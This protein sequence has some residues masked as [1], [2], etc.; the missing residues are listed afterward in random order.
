MVYLD[1][2]VL[3]GLLLI[4]AEEMMED[5]TLGIWIPTTIATGCLYLHASHIK[6]RGYHIHHV[7][8]HV[9]ASRTWQQ[10]YQGVAAFDIDDGEVA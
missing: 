4:D 8:L 7:I 6:T 2:A 3:A 1:D 5:R 10:L 9:L